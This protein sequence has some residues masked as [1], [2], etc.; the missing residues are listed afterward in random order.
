[1]LAVYLDPDR[2]DEHRCMAEAGVQAA[3][4]AM[5]ARLAEPGCDATLC[6]GI[7]GL[8]E[9]V[10]LCGQW[11]DGAYREKAAATALELLRRY[12]AAG[13]WPSGANAGGPNPSLMFGTA[14][15]GYQ[16]LRLC[17]PSVPP[18]LALTAAPGSG[19]RRGEDAPPKE[20]D[21]DG[22]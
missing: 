2:V 14:G 16:F 7:A 11:F 18:L 4:A 1:M 22:S 13:A 12:G 15:I 8:S 9:I 20:I 19:R 6:H 10:L 21:E 3:L 5:A 17:D